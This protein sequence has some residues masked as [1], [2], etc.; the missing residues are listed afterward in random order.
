MS[1]ETGPGSQTFDSSSETIE[2]RSS[3]ETEMEP[4][5]GET[6]DTELTLRSVDERIRQATDPMLKRVEELCAL[7]ASRTG[8]ESAGNSEASGS[9]R[10]REFSSHSRNRYD[11]T[12][13]TFWTDVSTFFPHFR[14]A[15]VDFR[16]YF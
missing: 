9:R 10:D 5:F 12:R 15:V 11:T 2:V 3:Q 4:A 7:L 8:M 13:K 14:A 6:P 1:E 16:F